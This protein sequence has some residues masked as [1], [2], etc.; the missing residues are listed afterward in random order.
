MVNAVAHLVPVLN[1]KE[2][3]VAGL[4]EI[5]LLCI[6]QGVPGL[7]GNNTNEQVQV[8]VLIGRSECLFSQFHH[9]TLFHEVVHPCQE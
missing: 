1:M 7:N 4:L 3:R 9:C 6:L 2:I 5:P 8:S